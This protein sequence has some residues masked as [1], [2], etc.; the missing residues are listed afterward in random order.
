MLP[1]PVFLSWQLTSV[2][3]P[4]EPEEASNELP[5]RPVLC[6]DET[7]FDEAVSLTLHKFYRGDHRVKSWK[8]SLKTHTH[9]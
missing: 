6:Q 7:C 8:M 5:G 2:L 1:D 3:I 4:I 9:T